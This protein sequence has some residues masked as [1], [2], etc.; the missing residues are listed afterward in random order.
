MALPEIHDRDF[1]LLLADKRLV[2]IHFTAPWCRP[3]RQLDP[4]M[5]RLSEEYEGMVRIVRLDIN[6]NKIVPQQFNVRIVPSV[7]IFQ[8]GKM[9]EKL[10]GVSHYERFKKAIS[11]QI[12]PLDNIV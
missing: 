5:A 12:S 7:L 1:N 9:V 10:L 6:K 11:H 4:I 8:N 2:V 3:C